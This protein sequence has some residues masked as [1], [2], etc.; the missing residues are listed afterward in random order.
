MLVTLSIGS[1]TGMQTTAERRE[2]E[3]YK[4]HK[5][6]KTVLFIFVLWLLTFSFSFAQNNHN[7]ID[8]IDSI[9]QIYQLINSV[10]NN[11]SHFKI[12]ETL[13]FND[14]NCQKLS[15]SLKLKPYFKADFDNNGFTDLLV[16][17]KLFEHTI[18][19]IMSYPNNKHLIKKLTRSH[20]QNC[21]FPVL[22]T[23]KSDTVTS[24][25]DYFFFDELTWKNKDSSRRIQTKKLIYKFQDFIEY[26]N[27]NN[28]YNIQK[29]QFSTMGCFGECPIFSLQIDSNR[30]AK[31][32]AHQ[33]NEPDGKFKGQIKSKDYIQIVE[34]LNYIDFPNLNDN[35]QVSWTDDQTSILKISYDNGKTKSIYDYGLIG[36]YGLDRL[37]DL[38]FQL[39]KNQNWRK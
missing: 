16:I 24:Y 34:L 20:F 17:G 9:D 11:F 7:R 28:F 39:R 3:F 2:L 6:M 26:N 38:L 22:A 15:D 25:I 23:I 8:K 27:S 30:K 31:Y 4:L 14:I 32:F 19:C 18:I 12:N 36:T 13:K 21:S 29:I 5:T 1:L 33:F 10:D 37:Y 35:Y